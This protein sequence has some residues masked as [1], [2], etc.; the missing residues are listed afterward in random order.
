MAV[1]LMNSKKKPDAIRTVRKCTNN[2]LQYGS[3]RKVSSFQ[4]INKMLMQ[5]CD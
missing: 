3:R 4:G 2:N 5:G 1:L